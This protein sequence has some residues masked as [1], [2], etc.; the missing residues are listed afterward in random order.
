MKKAYESV[1]GSSGLAIQCAW[2][3]EVLSMN[4]IMVLSDCLVVVVVL[5]HV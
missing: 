2:D 1:F 5:Y 3:T 4:E